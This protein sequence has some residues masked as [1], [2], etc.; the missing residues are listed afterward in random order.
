MSET[1]NDM[2]YD[3]I[4]NNFDNTLLEKHIIKS[5]NEIRSY[6]IDHKESFRGFDINA[7]ESIQQ[8]P[9]SKILN[10]KNERG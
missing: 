9:L 10:G 3:L 1:N 7:I 2:T 8:Q 6:L 5:S 4:G